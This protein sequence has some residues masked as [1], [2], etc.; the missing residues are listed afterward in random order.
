MYREQVH[1]ANLS[2]YQSQYTF[3]I[4]MN[5]IVNRILQQATQPNAKLQC[6][7]H[8][9]IVFIDHDRYLLYARIQPIDS[10]NDGFMKAILDHLTTPQVPNQMRYI[11]VF[12]NR[13]KKIFRKRN[14]LLCRIGQSTVVQN[15]RR[16][17]MTILQNSLIQIGFQW[18]F[19]NQ[20]F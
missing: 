1:S 19:C 16:Q 12:C 13:S 7:S 11:V 3:H 6:Q 18:V 9:Q 20:S 4:H 17:H 5:R 2:L 8:L 10:L 14:R 15:T